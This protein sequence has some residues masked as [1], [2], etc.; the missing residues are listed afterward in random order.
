MKKDVGSADP[1]D[2]EAASCAYVE[3]FA[4][5]VFSLADNE[6]RTGNATRCFPS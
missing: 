5:R 4:L 3:N 2:D 1:I 6:D